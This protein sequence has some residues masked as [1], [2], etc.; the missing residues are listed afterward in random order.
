MYTRIIRAQ[1]TASA[2]TDVLVGHGSMMVTVLSVWHAEEKCDILAIIS[3]AHEKTNLFQNRF[4]W[5]AKSRSSHRQSQVPKSLGKCSSL[6]RQSLVS[7][8]CKKKSFSFWYIE[9]IRFFFFQGCGKEINYKNGRL[10]WDDKR[11]ITW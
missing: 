3:G 1:V 7:H 2:R 5:H 8:C 11:K 10:T 4:R 6:R 9:K